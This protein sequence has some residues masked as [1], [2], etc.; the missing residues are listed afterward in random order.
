V[1]R[2]AILTVL[3]LPTSEGESLLDIGCGN[4]QFIARMRSFGWKVSGIDPD[5]VAASYGRSR[6]LNIETGTIRDLPGTD[7]YDVITLS[8]VVE[9]VSDPVALLRECAKRLRPVTGRLIVATPN[10]LSLG[11]WWF[12]KHWRGW[13]VPRH[14]IV[15]SPR[16]LR[17]CVERAGLIPKSLTTET[18]LAQMIYAQSASARGGAVGVGEQIN[19]KLT[20]KVAGRLFRIVEN[21]TSHINKDLGEEILCVCAKP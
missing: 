11:H 3:G 5:P 21:L 13:E 9:H 17:T 16:G 15:F 20:T 12:G 10:I 8:H 7:C 14:F 4:G 18:R 1:R 2:T 6:G 19:F